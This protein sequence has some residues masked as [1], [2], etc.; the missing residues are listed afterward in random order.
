MR[1]IAVVAGSPSENERL[2]SSQRLLEYGFRF[3]ATQKLIT[4]ETKITA[5]K[6]W[7]GKIDEVA[8]GTQEDILLTL[9]RSDFKTIKG[10]YKF[11]N[12]IQAP[13]AIGDVI[14][15]IEFVSNDRVVLSA[16]LIAIE[17]V[18]SKGFFGR[19]WAR[20][21]FWIMS[22]FSIGQDD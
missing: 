2:N 7:G 4:K 5:A 9:P 18:D 6:V 10:N 21:V 16:P 13:I 1:L 8:L 11:K 17:S 20:I 15:D 19:I 14:G 22:L 12:N 3:F